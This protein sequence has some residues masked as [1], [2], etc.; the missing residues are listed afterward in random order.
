MSDIYEEALAL[1]KKYQGKIK[2]EPIIPIKTRHDLSLF[3]TPGV[4]EPCRQIIKDKKLSF[5]LTWRGKTIAIISDGSATLGLG[6][7]GPEAC[8]PVM[9]GKAL[10]V[11]QFAGINCVPIV[12]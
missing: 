10:L 7:I 12:L 8:L 3:Y 4:A 6:N 11:Q 2:I 1:H 9:E 5:D